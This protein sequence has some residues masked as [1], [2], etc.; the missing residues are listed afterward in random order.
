MSTIQSQV[1]RNVFGCFGVKGFTTLVKSSDILV[2]IMEKL[3]LLEAKGLALREVRE[4]VA[5]DEHVEL[6]LGSATEIFNVHDNVDYYLLAVRGKNATP[7]VVT[8][9][10]N[11]N[12]LDF[13]VQK[14][15][16]YYRRELMNF[17]VHR[18]YRGKDPPLS[19]S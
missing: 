10:I 4:V 11:E 19:S 18:Y 13:E 16:M 15:S 14:K 5:S 7:L 3:G 17:Q 6:V 9:Q 8:L 1:K 2:R 12:P